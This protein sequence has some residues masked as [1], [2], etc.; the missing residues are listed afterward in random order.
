MEMWLLHH[1]VEIS[2]RWDGDYGY[3]QII[4]TF[5]H[6]NQYWSTLINIL[7]STSFTDQIVDETYNNIHPTIIVRT[8]FNQNWSIFLRY[9]N[10]NIRTLNWKHFRTEQLI[11]KIDIMHRFLILSNYSTLVLILID[12]YQL[13]AGIAPP[14][15][16]NIHSN[17]SYVT[18]T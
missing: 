14:I 12:N 10:R 15:L 5:N 16:E 4:Y 18:S 1:Y 11:W 17:T 13:V 3:K 2:R 9:G 6:L 7:S 8:C